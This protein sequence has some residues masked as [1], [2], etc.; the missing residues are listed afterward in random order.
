[1]DII[2]DLPPA[3]QNWQ[4]APALPKDGEGLSF[5]LEGTPADTTPVWQ[6]DL[7]GGAQEAAAQLEQVGSQLSASQ[8]ALQDAS[9]RLDEFIRRYQVG[10][11]TQ[12]SF[13]ATALPA[14]ES[15][16]RDWLEQTRPEALEFGVKAQAPSQLEMQRLSAQVQAALEKL[17][18][19]ALH[20][21]W[22]ETRV[23]GRWLARSV[24]SWGGD[25]DTVW[26][27]MIQPEDANLHQ[28]N[29]RLAI[30]SRG[31]LLRLVMVVTTGALKIALLLTTPGGA[32]LA[33]PAAWKFVHR[34]LSE[35]ESYQSQ[36]QTI[37]ET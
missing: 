7:P 26:G 18:Q 29:L 28:H 16:L 30:L 37:Q 9:S 33:L 17:L 4:F 15:E 10:E 19:Q 12:V 36:A 13:A 24:V 31:T 35:I 11:M 22:V 2:A 21:A 5:G 23:E 32:V 34:I 8:L 3:F 6:I 20:F 27:V 14:P 25:A 1:M